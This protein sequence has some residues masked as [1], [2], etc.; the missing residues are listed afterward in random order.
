L[1][2]VNEDEQWIV[3]PGDFIIT[4]GGRQPGKKESGKGDFGDISTQRISVE[5]EIFVIE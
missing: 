5:G 2:F 1:A 3:E 4:I